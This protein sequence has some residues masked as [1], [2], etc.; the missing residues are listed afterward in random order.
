VPKKVLSFQTDSRGKL[1]PNYEGPSAM[2]LVTTDGDKYRRPMHAGV[3]KK[4]SVKK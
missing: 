1:A 3:V 4:Y 2:T